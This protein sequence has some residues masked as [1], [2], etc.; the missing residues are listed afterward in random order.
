VSQHTT[1]P[2][3]QS[4]QG[5]FDAPSRLSQL[6][7]HPATTALFVVILAALIGSLSLAVWRF[8]LGLPDTSTLSQAQ[9]YGAVQIFDR[10]DRLVVTVHGDEYRKPVDLKLISPHMRAAI[11]AAEDHSFYQHGGISLSGIVRAF[12]SNAR[13]GH[14]VEG[15]STITQQLVKNLFFQNRD[16]TIPTK[17][18]EMYLAIELE[19]RHSKDWILATYLNQVYFGNGAWGVERAANRYFSKPASKL[20]L[21]ESAFLAGLVNA[22]SDLSLSA[23]RKRA[24]ARQTQILKQ[25]QE[26]GLASKPDVQYALSHPITFKEGSAPLQK[27]PYYV[28]SVIQLLRK[29][30][31][32]DHLWRQPL[33]VY[34]NLDPVAQEQAERTLTAGIKRAPPGVSQGALVSISVAD[35]AVLAI[36]GGVGNFWKYQFNRATNPHTAGSAFKPFV[37]LAALR[38]RAIG[39]DTLVDDYPVSIDMPAQPV[40]YSPKNFDGDFMGT[41]S[42]RKALV[43]SRNVCAVRVAEQVGLDKVVETARLAGIQ[44]RLDPYPSLALGSCAVSPFELANAYATLARG[45]IAI[46]PSLVRRIEDGQG[47]VVAVFPAKSERV[48]DAEP[49]AQLVDVLVD[50]VE[51]GT[52]R[53]AQL[54]D[55]TVA[56]KT[57]T[58]DQSRD[59]WFVGFTPGVVT[60]V[61]GGNDDNLPIPGQRVTGGSVMAAIWR[62]YMSAFYQAHPTPPAGFAAPTYPL[63]GDDGM[64]IEEE[65]PG[66][67]GRVVEGLFGGD[68]HEQNKEK[69]RHGFLGRVVRGLFKLF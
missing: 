56:G 66:L 38:Y 46:E 20:T 24:I 7:R 49:V 41:M 48:F 11:L 27:Y 9:P 65:E 16:R 42:I 23:N 47:K 68:P 45:G 22:P 57:G 28:A 52:G 21:G 55:R 3:T 2:E 35:G 37:Y 40:T 67:V 26:Y 61:W 12:I 63:R 10:N 25:A 54:P 64:M 34:T 17:L 33:S 62:D 6:M 5:L 59:I 51:R 13:A 8:M 4:P 43:L 39:P 15:G 1:S 29:R 36:V 18:K 19:R 60:A 14:I 53:Q 31:G 50:V 32:D 58:S 30:L 69:Q 44:S